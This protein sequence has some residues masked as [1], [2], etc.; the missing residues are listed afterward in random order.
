[1]Y[2]CLCKDTSHPLEAVHSNHPHWGHTRGRSHHPTLEKHTRGQ[3]RHMHSAVIQET[4]EMITIRVILSAYVCD[5]S[6]H[7]VHM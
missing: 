5:T 3:R 1:M 6:Y 4:A 2:T 7:V